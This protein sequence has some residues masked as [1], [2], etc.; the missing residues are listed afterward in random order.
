MITASELKKL[1]EELETTKRPIIFFDDDTDGLSSFVLFYRYVKQFCEEAKGIIVRSTPILKDDMYIRKLEEYQPDKVFILDKPLV[2]QDFLDKIKV[3][4]VYLDHH[5]LQHLKDVHY[6]NPLKHTSK[7]FKP[8]N[9]PT[10]YWAYQTTKD[11]S[12]LWLAMVGC[13]GDWFMPEFSKE[14]SKK[15][16]DLYP[17]KLKIRNPGTVLHETELGKLCRIIQFNLKGTMQDVLASVKILTRINDPYEILHQTTPQGKFI[18]KR[19]DALNKTYESVKSRVKVTDDKL[20]LF[21]YEEQQGFASDLANEI[22][23]ENPGKVI[24][25]GMHKDGEMKCALRADTLNMRDILKESLVGIDGHGGGHEHACGAAI[26]D[27]DFEKFVDNL[28]KNIDKF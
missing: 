6:F 15:Y 3:K 14:F 18:Y 11:K 5:P 8:D 17:P 7:K 25:I 22:Q 19:Y 1:R 4:K 27:H 12:L 9:R 28:R 20:I 2:S 24:L 16:P 23:Y 13:T 10:T 21:T 26:K